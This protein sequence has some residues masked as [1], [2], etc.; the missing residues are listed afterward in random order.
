MGV[1]MSTWHQ[2]VAM[3]TQL[4][5]EEKEK[6]VL[7]YIPVSVSSVARGCLMTENSALTSVRFL[8]KKHVIPPGSPIVTGGASQLVLNP[9]SVDR[10][11]SLQC[12]T[13]ASIIHRNDSCGCRCKYASVRL[14]KLL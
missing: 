10:E 2:T 7:K 4:L 9:L 1:N 8:L 5:A 3:F 12:K 14:L 13:R 6:D 11:Q